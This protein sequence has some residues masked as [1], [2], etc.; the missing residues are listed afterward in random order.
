[1]STSCVSP[2]RAWCVECGAGRPC[3]HDAPAL[4]MSQTAEQIAM[5]VETQAD[6]ADCSHDLVSVIERK[7]AKE[8][9]QGIRAGAW[10]KGEKP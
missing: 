5:W 8:L 1:M 10:R 6:G 3:R 9:V 2:R 4:V 7:L